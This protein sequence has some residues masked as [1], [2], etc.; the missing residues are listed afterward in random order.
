M[1]PCDERRNIGSGDTDIAVPVSR[2]DSMRGVGKNWTPQMSKVK[3]EHP[4][5]AGDQSAWLQHCLSI[6][7]TRLEVAL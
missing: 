5:D 4:E 2:T 3:V 1:Q 7:P 6:Q